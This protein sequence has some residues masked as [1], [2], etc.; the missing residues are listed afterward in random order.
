MMQGSDPEH[1]HYCCIYLIVA[2]CILCADVVYEKECVRPLVQS[3]LALSHRK[4]VIYLA[5]ERRAPQV[6]A[7]FMRHMDAYFHWK[8][9]DRSEL[10]TGYIKDAIEVFEMRPKKR[11]VPE[12]MRIVVDETNAASQDPNAQEYHPLFKGKPSGAG[13]A[14]GEDPYDRDLWE[15]LLG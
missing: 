4:T 13:N 12:E 14:Q 6:R 5:N 11:K 3:I 2:D 9:V 15:D 8:E 1:E 7:E 10:D